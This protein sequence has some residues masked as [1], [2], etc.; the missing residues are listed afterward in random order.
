MVWRAAGPSG[1]RWG[2]WRR[3]G[4]SAAPPP[5]PNADTSK[6]GA[7]RVGADEPPSSATT[8]SLRG[9]IRRWAGLFQTAC[10]RHQLRSWRVVEIPMGLCAPGGAREREAQGVIT[11]GY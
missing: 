10:H 8:K 6:A 4:F 2:S 1:G 7:G 9:L 5:S 3:K 11:C